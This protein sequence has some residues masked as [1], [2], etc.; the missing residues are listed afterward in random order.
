ME[1]IKQKWAGKRALKRMVVLIVC[2]PWLQIMPNAICTAPAAHAPPRSSS[3]RVHNIIR[4]RVGTTV[5]QFQ[6]FEQPV[7]NAAL[8]PAVRKRA[9]G[10]F[11]FTGTIHAASLVQ[12][13][14]SSDCTFLLAPSRLGI[15]GSVENLLS[16]VRI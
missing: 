12:L 8:L 6:D 7:P 9:S 10:A 2:G 11:D 15:I 13:E 3:A 14:P 1:N 4:R 5:V 16:V